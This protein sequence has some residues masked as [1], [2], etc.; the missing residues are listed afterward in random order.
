MIHH[1]AISNNVPLYKIAEFFGNLCK[2]LIIEFIP[3]TDSQVQRLLVS[4]ED[5]FDEYTEEN[6]KIEF[7]KIFDIHEIIP[8]KDSKR[9]IYLME[10]R[11]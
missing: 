11:L 1:L 10:K 6:F 8:V 4:R 5:I 7:K 2:S 3:K 9:I